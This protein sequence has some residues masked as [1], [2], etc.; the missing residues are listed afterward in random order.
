MTVENFCQLPPNVQVF[1]L[2]LA[3]YHEKIFLPSWWPGNDRSFTTKLAP[4]AIKNGGHPHCHG[5]LPCSQLRRATSEF[6][7]A[8]EYL[9]L[10]WTDNTSIVCFNAKRSNEITN[11]QHNIQGISLAHVIVFHQQSNSF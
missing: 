9:L 3:A 6:A 11:T 4:T 5:H 1:L 10:T 8:R 2:E 7:V